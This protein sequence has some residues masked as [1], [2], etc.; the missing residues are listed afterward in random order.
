MKTL[1]TVTDLFEQ[2]KKEVEELDMV[3]LIRLPK[4]EGLI[5]ARQVGVEQ[6]TGEVF[7]FL[8]SHCKFGLIDIY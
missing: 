5:R 6:A 4:Q 2:V 7:I 3:T 8:D 1:N